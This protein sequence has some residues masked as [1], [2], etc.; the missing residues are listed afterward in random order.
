MLMVPKPPSPSL[1]WKMQVVLLY[2]QSG[3]LNVPVSS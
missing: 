2:W 3:V 1:L